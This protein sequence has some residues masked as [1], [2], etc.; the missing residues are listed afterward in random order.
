M[1][2]AFLGALLFCVSLYLGSG[3]IYL[4]L[5]GGARSENYISSVE[6]G[7]ISTVFAICIFFLWVYILLVTLNRR[8]IVGL[9]GGVLVLLSM[10]LMLV[11][12]VWAEYAFVSFAVSIFIISWFLFVNAYIYVVGREK[13]LNLVG[14]FLFLLV[15]ASVI[16]A[17]FFPAYGLSVGTHDGS[18]QGVFTHKNS[19]G[20]I[21]VLAFIFILFSNWP[22]TSKV[23]ALI[24]CGI[25]VYK[26]SSSAALTFLIAVPLLSLIWKTRIGRFRFS[27]MFVLFLTALLLVLVGWV[28][29]GIDPAF[30]NNRGRI[31]SF[32]MSKAF[33]APL[34]GHGLYQYPKFSEI[35]SELLRSSIGFY[36]RSAHNGFLDAYF[37]F[38]VLSIF[39]VFSFFF[40]IFQEVRTRILWFIYG[41]FMMYINIFESNLF[42][43]NMFFMLMILLICCGGRHESNKTAL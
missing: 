37:S 17:L 29:F 22:M 42:S 38:G 16:S 31:W 28:I 24:I 18:W 3:S 6:S 43:I 4:F 33:E 14:V 27:S 7:L 26:S 19:F 39:L 36:V 10:L 9:R 20:Y 35:N 25:A 5:E 13:V 41:V 11:S 8:G 21:A 12:S 40:K 2:I 1:F 30:L 34:I 23:V 32:V 15:A